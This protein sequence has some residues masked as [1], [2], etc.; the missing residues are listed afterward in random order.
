MSFHK[1]LRMPKQQSSHGWTFLSEKFITHFFDEI[2]DRLIYNGEYGEHPIEVVS[3]KKEDFWRVVHPSAVETIAFMDIQYKLGIYTIRD[4]VKVN[5][6]INI[7][8][9]WKKA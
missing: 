7:S 5:E 8:H 1:K 9:H 2:D 6:A 4:I 3:Y